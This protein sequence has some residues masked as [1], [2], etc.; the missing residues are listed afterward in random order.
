MPSRPKIWARDPDN[1]FDVKRKGI[2][3]DLANLGEVL[4]DSL[5]VS[6]FLGHE[7]CGGEHRKASVL[8]FLGLHDSEF[9]F[10]FGLEIE[11]IET[12]VSGKVSFTEKTG[13]VDG[14]VLGFNPSNG[15]TVLLTSTNTDHQDQPEWNGDLGQMGDGRSGNLGIEEER[16]SLDLFSDEESNGGEHGNT[17]MGE[18]G[19]TV[20]AK[21]VVIGLLGKSKGVEESD[22]IKGTDQSVDNA[23]WGG[24]GLG[25]SGSLLSKATESGSGSNGGKEGGGDEFHVDVCVWF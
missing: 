11:G 18:F 7:T 6:E 19:F 13:L 25:R 9:V 2:C 3:K 16:A 15:G 20:S 17:S 8:E 4:E 5:S 10:V 14:D 23:G 12:D 21:S 24:S 22:G 1:C